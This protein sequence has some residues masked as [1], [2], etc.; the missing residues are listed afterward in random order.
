MAR[1]KDGRMGVSVNAETVDILDKVK[2]LIWLQMG[3]S[4]S[5]T[6]AIQVVAKHYLNNQQDIVTSSHNVQQGE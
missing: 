6:Q 4:A 5:Y 1:A 3:I 2:K